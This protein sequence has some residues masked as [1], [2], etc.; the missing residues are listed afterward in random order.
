MTREQRAAAI[1]LQHTNEALAQ[2]G[3]PPVGTP[4]IVKF[5][6]FGPAEGVVLALGSQGGALIGVGSDHIDAKPEWVTRRRV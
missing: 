4:V 2:R 5:A 3:M 6:G 1:D